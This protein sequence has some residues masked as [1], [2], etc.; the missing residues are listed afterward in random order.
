M[1]ISAEQDLGW[2]L[3]VTHTT[4]GPDTRPSSLPTALL[5]PPLQAWLIAVDLPG[6]PDHLVRWC[7]QRLVLFLLIS[8]CVWNRTQLGCYL[9]PYNSRASFTLPSCYT[10]VTALLVSLQA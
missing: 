8:L 10:L 5:V 9:Y 7:M 3:A 6:L 4:A 1:C 2:L